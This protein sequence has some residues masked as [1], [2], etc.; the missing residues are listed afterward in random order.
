MYIGGHNDR[1]HNDNVIG[2]YADR[3]F[4]VQV[5]WTAWQIKQDFQKVTLRD[6][7]MVAIADEF[8]RFGGIRAQFVPHEFDDQRMVSITTTP[9]MIEQ[10]TML[11]WP[12][13]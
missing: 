8:N 6:V 13:K 2:T 12:K 10:P 9:T 4:E 11:S 7:F 5:T 3:S 1:D